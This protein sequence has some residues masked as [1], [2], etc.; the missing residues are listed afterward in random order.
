MSLTSRLF[1]RA[2]TQNEHVQATK[3]IV[4]NRSSARLLVVNLSGWLGAFF[5]D[6]KNLRDG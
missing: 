4:A 3:P 1:G 5:A 6:D 2:A